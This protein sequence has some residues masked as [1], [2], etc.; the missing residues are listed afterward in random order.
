MTTMNTKLK[1]AALALAF[2]SANNYQ[3]STCFAQG[4]LTPPGAPAPT[5][6]SLDQIEPRTPISTAPFVISEGGSYYLTTNVT[7]S[8]GDAITIA[9]NNVTLDLKGFTIASTLPAASSD[10]AILLSGGVTN[11]AI[12]NGHISSGVTNTAAGVFGGSGFSYGVHY[13]GNLPGN[14]RVKDVSVAGV[15]Y[16]GIYL[17]TGDST[18]AES[19][20]VTRAG[21]IG[22]GAD[23][24]SDSTAQYCGGYGIFANTAHNCLGSVVG[25]GTGVY[26]ISA[27]NCYGV[28]AGDYGNGLEAYTAN[29]CYGLNSANGD[30]LFASIANCCFGMSYG[31]GWAGIRAG[32]QALN[33]YG[34]TSGQ[35]F[36]VRAAIVQG[37]YGESGANGFGVYAR[38]ATG[39]YG[40]STTA[41]GIGLS[42]GTASNCA[43]EESSGGTAI[44]ATIANGCIAYSGTNIITYKYNMP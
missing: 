13:S 43:G 25:G 24:V 15:L 5:M 31:S 9:A 37:C 21:S 27:N 39:C 20:V 44:Q 28:S 17:G 30:G 34:S 26:A 42:A 36:G 8:S 38:V 29:N 33:C 22:I 1:L 35:G 16:H 11:I 3:L 10:T 12:Y 19:C 40:K 4:S 14:V 32:I 6:K 2:L 18:V 41:G 7:V 23:S